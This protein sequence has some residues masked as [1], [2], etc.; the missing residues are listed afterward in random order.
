MKRSARRKEK[1]FPKSADKLMELQFNAP[2]RQ[3]ETQLVSTAT[4]FRDNFL[5][6]IGVVKNRHENQALS[7]RR[8]LSRTALFVGGEIR[9]IPVEAAIAA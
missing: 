9:R 6:P 5:I 2:Q 7:Q 1:K 8:M 3:N 4:T